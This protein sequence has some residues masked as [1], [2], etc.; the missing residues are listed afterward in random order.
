MEWWY[1][2]NKH[3]VSGENKRFLK[4]KLNEHLV[5]KN[6]VGIASLYDDDELFYIKTNNNTTMNSFLF[7]HGFEEI[8][9][10]S[11]TREDSLNL[12]IADN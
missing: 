3:S 2:S 7:K 6:S 8:Y 4:N 1:K 11:N 10:F 5:K 12:I 9:D